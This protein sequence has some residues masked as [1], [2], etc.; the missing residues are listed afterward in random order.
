MVWEGE[1]RGS[2]VSWMTNATVY[3]ATQQNM[4]KYRWVMEKVLLLYSSTDLCSNCVL[5]HSLPVQIHGEK[6][7]SILQC[8]G[9]IS[10]LL[11][12]VVTSSNRCL[13][14]F[15]I[16]IRAQ[17]WEEAFLNCLW[18]FLSTE[19]SQKCEAQLKYGTSSTH[20]EYL[21]ICMNE[22]IPSASLHVVIVP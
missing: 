17:C 6:P 11:T 7:P 16:T 4:C 14:F 22:R 8:T 21:A 12:S 3:G 2:T 5:F 9:E 20:T 15:P 19:S 1:K 13:S 18:C 10:G